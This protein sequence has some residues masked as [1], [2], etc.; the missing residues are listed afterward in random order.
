M[1]IAK[2]RRLSAKLRRESIAQSAL[3]LFARRGFDGVTTNELAESCGI[4]EAL[5][6]RHFPSKVA[7]YN[8]ILRHYSDLIDPE[9][10]RADTLPPSTETLVKLVFLF[11]Y[12]IVVKESTKGYEVM[13]LF[14]RSFVD[15]GDFAFRFL[16]SRRL[17]AIR[18]S[19]V[20]S[21]AEARKSGDAT[22]LDV[23]PYN[24]FWYVQHTASTGCLIRLPP[25]R[26]MNYRGPLD[27]A[28]GD[29]VRFALR[30]IGL[31]EAALR[32]HAS[33]EAFGEIRKNPHL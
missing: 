12:R 25:K 17:R 32:R 2:P 3:S 28:V 30:G 16:R 8:E 18:Q 10:F 26:A 13:R 1:L 31:T 14:Y 15:D 19:F 5:I 22:V 7:L 20:D 9:S 27:E 11:V 4:S 33:A 29:M 23:D 6:F 21:L 24:L